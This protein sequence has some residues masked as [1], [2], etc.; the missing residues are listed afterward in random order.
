MSERS[1]S[2][3]LGVILNLII[4]I[5][6]L[7][8]QQECK[9]LKPR[10]ADYYSGP[11]VKGLAHGTGE[12]FGIDQYR[13]DF[14]KGLPDGIGTYIWQ[15]GDRYDGEWKEGL[16]HGRGVMTF[17]TAG[18]DS[19]QAGS[20]KRD[21]YVGEDPSPRYSVLYRQGVGRVTC[22]RMGISRN[23]VG[24]KF[25]RS[26]ESSAGT[27]SDLMLT[28]SSGSEYIS[29]TFIGFE[30]VHYP[31]EGRVRFTAPNAFYSAMLDCEVRYVINQPGAWTVTIY[32]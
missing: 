27:I 19:I 31:F 17:I 30:N 32:Y 3:L 6:P 15:S 18:D 7:F 12:A 9:V 8:G 26:G 22:V 13:G 11:C 10:I 5:A 1:Y 28:G 24:I 23:Y 20:W 29:D 14:I 4:G 16:R 2:V 21:L 25:T